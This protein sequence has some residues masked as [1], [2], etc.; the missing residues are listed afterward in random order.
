MV[1]KILLKLYLPLDKPS[2]YSYYYYLTDIPDVCCLKA[3][4]HIQGFLQEEYQKYKDLALKK[5]LR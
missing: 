2:N 1:R 3:F 5:A 4:G